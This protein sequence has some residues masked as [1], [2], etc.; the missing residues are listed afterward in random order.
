M[1]KKYTKGEMKMTDLY[2]D[3]D[4][5][6]KDTI[7]VSYKT[8]ITENIDFCRVIKALSRFLRLP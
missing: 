5:V 4:G 6:I 7:K 1:R 2:I 3:F 8:N